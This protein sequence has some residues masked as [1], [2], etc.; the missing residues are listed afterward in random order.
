MVGDIAERKQKRGSVNIKN[1]VL[2]ICENDL[3]IDIVLA[4]SER[5]GEVSKHT[6]NTYVTDHFL[7]KVNISS[8]RMRMKKYL[9]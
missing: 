6:V 8:S 5:G 3:S 9:R 4:V 7:L 1:S 2:E